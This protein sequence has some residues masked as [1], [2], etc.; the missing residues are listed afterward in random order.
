MYCFVLSSALGLA[1]STFEGQVPSLLGKD[2]EAWI[3]ELNS[4]EI[5]VRRSAAFALGRLGQ[6]SPEVQTALRNRL[7][8]PK[9]D[10]AVQDMAA[11]ALG[12]LL[13]R[14]DARADVA[15]VPVLQN[16]LRKSPEKRVRRRA[17]YALGAFGSL[18]EPARSD[19]EAALDDPEPIVKQNAAWALGRLKGKPGRATVEGLRKLLKYQAKNT[20][21]AALVRRDV[22]TAL[23]ELGPA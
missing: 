21:A 14:P 23:G 5:A 4:P 12:D 15:A 3:A 9:E 17:A 19:L 6:D 11:F 7:R 16:L 13:A 20:A 1:T 22:V 18:A 10:A 8:D 2:A